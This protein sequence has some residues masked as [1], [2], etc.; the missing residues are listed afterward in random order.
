MKPVLLLHALLIACLAGCARSSSP[1][2]PED[3]A[4]STGG[5]TRQFKIGSTDFGIDAATSTFAVDTTDPDRPTITVEL[6]GDQ[7]TFDAISADEDSEWSWALYPPGFFLR[8]FPAQVDPAT[9]VATAR[10]RLDDL[11]HYE[12]GIYM[13]EY[14]DIDNVAVK[15]VPDKSLEVT[16]RVDLLGEVD[17]FVIR[18]QR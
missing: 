3:G 11:D 5:A 13:M 15:V 18:W 14:S 7:A 17:D 12:F 6:A 2:R 4:P 10:V 16:G 8:S 9:G 1:P